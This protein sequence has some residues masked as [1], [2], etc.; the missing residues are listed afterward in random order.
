MGH[1]R[2]RTAHGF[3]RFRGKTRGDLRRQRQ[4]QEKVVTMLI[5]Y[6]LTIRM[7]LEWENCILFENLCGPLRKTLRSL[8]LNFLNR[9]EREGKWQVPKDTC[10]WFII[11]HQR[12]IHSYS[13]IYG[14][15]I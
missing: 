7:R 6:L 15:L 5:F 11:G 13:A 4:K 3:T 14:I 10:R 8:R 12:L 2:D 9:T 1:N